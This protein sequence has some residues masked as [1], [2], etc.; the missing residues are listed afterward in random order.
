MFTSLSY[1]HTHTHTHTHIHARTCA[2]THTRTHAR[3]HA[4]TYI[5][6]SRDSRLFVDFSKVFDSI[7]G[8][9][10]K[11]ILLVYGLLNNDVLQRHE[12]NGSLTWWWHQLLWHCG[13]SLVKRCICINFIH[14]VPR[15]R[16]T[17]II[18]SNEGKW[19]YTKI[20]RWYPSENIMNVDYADDPALL[21]NN[22]AQ[23][24]L[25]QSLVS[26]RILIK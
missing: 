21:A 6:L 11:Q 22:S 9:K 18:R 19:C 16:T 24:C 8:K 23:V 5:V 20:G 17:N 13:W 7:H 26:T 3:T 25:A 4:H 14:N 15:L 2:H 1:A 10:M 12:N